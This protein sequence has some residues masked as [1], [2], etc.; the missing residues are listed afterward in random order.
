ML[1]C[2]QLQ[3]FVI[4]RPFNESKLFLFPS[5]ASRWLGE[6]EKKNEKKGETTA[7]VKRKHTESVILLLSINKLCFILLRMKSQLQA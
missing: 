7:D 2:R 5:Q 3:A 4:F 1:C 6:L